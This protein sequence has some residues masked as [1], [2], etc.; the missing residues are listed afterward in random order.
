MTDFVNKIKYY[1]KVI[2]AVPI[3]E[4]M[5]RIQNYIIDYKNNPLDELKKETATELYFYL[6]NETQAQVY[7]FQTKTKDKTIILYIA[8]KIN[9]VS[10]K[11]E[12]DKALASSINNIIKNNTFQGDIKILLINDMSPTS[13][14]L[15][16]MNTV[17]YSDLSREIRA[18]FIDITFLLFNP[19]KNVDVPKH[20]LLTEDEKKE[21]LKSLMV[22]V[23][24]LPYIFD[25]DP[26][27]RFYGWDKPDNVIKIT[28]YETPEREHIP[29][30]YYRRVIKYNKKNM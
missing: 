18:V 8:K 27:V 28:R 13:E 17:D 10:T 1:E 20:E 26:I 9:K 11:N 23:S 22:N 14:A 2:Q 21:V 12:I 15:K 7:I 30:Y 3:I 4:E 24:N 29:T 19:I 6:Q 16:S 25:V 5:L